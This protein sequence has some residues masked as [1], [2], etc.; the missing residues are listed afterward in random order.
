MKA[1]FR[2]ADLPEE[3]P[4][5]A[6]VALF[7]AGP[8]RSADERVAIRPVS[9]RRR[10][11]PGRAIAIGGAALA[12]VGCAVFVAA[13]KEGDRDVE[14]EARPDGGRPSA[15]TPT[16]PASATGGPVRPSG[17]PSISSPSPSASA[18]RSR[19]AVA[20]E[21]ASASRSPAASGTTDTAP[22]AGA[23]SSASTVSGGSG[24]SDGSGGSGVSDASGAEATTSG[25]RPAQGGGTLR[26][27]DSG[28]EVAELQR[29]LAQ[30]NLYSDPVD[31]EYDDGVR[32]A[33]QR[34]QSGYGVRGDAEGVYGPN[35]RRSLEERTD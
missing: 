29:R 2:P 24:G 8:A 5:P 7:P 9:H 3:G 12:V 6:D 16:D 1:V 33:V 20:D 26:Q 14:D 28:P 19:R 4:D 18:S 15:V 35:T 34:Y 10:R 17:S 23:P 27:G 25:G 32:Y 30:V 11:G 21:E 22:S 31:G 13:L